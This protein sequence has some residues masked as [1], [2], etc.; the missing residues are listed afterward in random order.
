M[1]ATTIDLQVFIVRGQRVALDSQ[2]AALY[3]VSTKKLNQQVKRNPDRFPA[4]FVFQLTWAE[5][6][7][8]DRRSKTWARY[9]PHAFTE[10]GAGMLASVI[11]GRRATTISIEI[12]R[13]FVS[14]RGPEI[15][16]EAATP[17]TIRSKAMFE[18]LRDAILTHER[19]RRFVT[20]IPITY[21]LQAGT[22]G[23]IKIGSTRNLPVRINTLRTMSP[24][25]LTLRGVVYGDVELECHQVLGAWRLHGEWFA[26]S[27]V[28]LN[29]IRQKTN[30]NHSR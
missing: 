21:F 28:V 9:R 11:R 6:K 12:L 23:P 16:A 26:P 18:A 27:N 1:G 19:E 3:G 15:A 4:D 22:D 29:F 30:E 14:Q 5:S 10:Q 25:P 2:L 7:A 24:V 8:L 17:E 20:D 13:A